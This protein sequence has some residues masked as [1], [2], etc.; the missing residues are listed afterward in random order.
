MI[1]P[2]PNV[3]VCTC[4]T[5]HTHDE[6]PTNYAHTST[7]ARTRA[8]THTHTH[9]PAHGM[10][11]LKALSPSLCPSLHLSHLPLY[12]SFS[13]PPYPHPRA[14]FLSLSLSLSRS[15]SL[16]I[17]FS[18]LFLFSPLSVSLSLPHY[19]PQSPSLQLRGGRR[20]RQDLVQSTPEHQRHLLLLLLL[21]CRLDCFPRW[22]ARCCARP[23][24]PLSLPCAHALSRTH[25][26]P[27]R[28]LPPRSCSPSLICIA[29]FRS[30][31]HSIP[32]Q[33]Y[34]NALLSYYSLYL[35]PFVPL[36]IL[37]PPL[38]L[39]SLLLRQSSPTN[40]APPDSEP[41]I[42]LIV[43]G[44]LCP[45]PSPPPPSPPHPCF[46]THLEN[47]FYRGYLCVCSSSSSSVS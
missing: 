5:Q 44:P 43:R 22:S 20:S 38:L 27:P 40:S 45:C 6:D 33:Q 18:S 32:Y 14:L 1:P 11:V 10:L 30:Y 25:L 39:L 2:L 12:L 8:H 24:F 26:P 16:S 3:Y 9:T 23:P 36:P 29:P 19:L 28:S 15:L 13:P 37:A 7:H 46:H 34:C 21:L 47:T 17:S 31:N 35:P 41:M 42:P 4:D